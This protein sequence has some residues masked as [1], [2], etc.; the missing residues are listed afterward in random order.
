LLDPKR[1]RDRAL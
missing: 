1:K